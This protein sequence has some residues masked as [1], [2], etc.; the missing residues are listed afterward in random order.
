MRKKH[1]MGPSECESTVT[2]YKNNTWAKG[3]G[4]CGEMTEVCVCVCVCFVNGL[5]SN[6]LV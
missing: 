2:L 1:L 6:L 4:L 5:G 3:S